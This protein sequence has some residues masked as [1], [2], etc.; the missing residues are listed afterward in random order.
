M[1]IARHVRYCIEGSH[2]IERCVRKRQLGEVSLNEVGVWYVLPR[3]LYL[4]GR[5]VYPDHAEPTRQLLSGG[6]PRTTAQVQDAVP[7]IGLDA[8]PPL[9]VSRSHA[10]VTGCDDQLPWVPHLKIVFRS[11]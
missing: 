8:L 5:D 2:A 1:L 3:Q 10:I 11:P 9:E 6:D 4:S 7:R